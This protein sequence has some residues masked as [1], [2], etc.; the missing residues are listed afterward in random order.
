M[1]GSIFFKSL[2]SWIERDPWTS[3]PWARE[4]QIDFGT[5]LMWRS[6][7]REY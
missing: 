3:C 2:V 6:Q 1:D 7:E 4:E 5:L